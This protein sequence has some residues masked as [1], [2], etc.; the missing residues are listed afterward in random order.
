MVMNEGIEM[1]ISTA[2]RVEHY[3]EHTGIGQLSESRRG[4]LS[5]FI[6]GRRMR[7]EL[8]MLDSRMLSDI[9]LTREQVMGMG[10]LFANSYPARRG[11]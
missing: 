1:T 11:S 3:P 4:W 5:K 9:G 10:S 6:A 2:A 7:R 8:M